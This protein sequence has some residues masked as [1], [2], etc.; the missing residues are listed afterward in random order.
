MWEWLR[1]T[2][3]GIHDAV[4]MLNMIIVTSLEVCFF[5]LS[6]FLPQWYCCKNWNVNDPPPIWSFRSWFRQSW[7]LFQRQHDWHN[8]HFSWLTSFFHWN[9][10]KFYV[11]AWISWSVSFL[12]I[13]RYVFLLMSVSY[14]GYRLVVFGLQMIFLFRRHKN[15][16]K[17][18][19]YILGLQIVLNK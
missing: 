14:S 19:H 8:Y 10:S 7:L 13:K 17:F 1:F 11:S 6:T 4:H 15:H 18:C 5:L 2:E 12:L 16:R 9:C 3:S